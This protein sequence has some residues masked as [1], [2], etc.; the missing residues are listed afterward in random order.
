MLQQ[1]GMGPSPFSQYWRSEEVRLRFLIPNSKLFEPVVTLRSDTDALEIRIRR[2]SS[3]FIGA[4]F[5]HV[6]IKHA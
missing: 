4:I 1:V 6:W 5:Q 2:Q 3:S